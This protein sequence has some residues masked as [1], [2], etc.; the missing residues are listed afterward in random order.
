MV[1]FGVQP[2]ALKEG[3]ILGCLVIQATLVNQIIETQQKDE[4]LRKWFYKMIVRIRMSGA[5]KVTEDLDAG[6]AS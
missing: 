5:S 2:I 3:R 4:G 6:T 1:K